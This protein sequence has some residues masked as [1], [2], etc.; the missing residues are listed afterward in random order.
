MQNDGKTCKI[1][2]FKSMRI[3]HLSNIDKSVKEEKDE[4]SDNENYFKLYDA[5]KFLDSTKSINEEEYFNITKKYN[6]KSSNENQI[7]TLDDQDDEKFV[8]EFKKNLKKDSIHANYKWK[9]N[10]EDENEI[11]F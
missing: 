1:S 4:F 6:L 10:L 11:S 3:N 5:K 8:E 2:S 7:I 9:I